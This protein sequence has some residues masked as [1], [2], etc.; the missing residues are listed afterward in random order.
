MIF[1]DLFH[2]SGIFEILTFLNGY[3]DFGVNKLP[4]AIG[5][6]PSS[7]LLSLYIL[8]VFYKKS[9]VGFF[10]FFYNLVNKFN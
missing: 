6:I 3:G 1:I 8:P 2:S 10:N 9:Y 4:W 5:D 7:F